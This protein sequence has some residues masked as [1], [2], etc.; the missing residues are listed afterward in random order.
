MNRERAKKLLPV[1]QAFAE[2]KAIEMRPEDD[3]RWVDVSDPAWSHGMEYRIKPETVK[4]LRYKRFIA[5]HRGALYV[6]CQYESFSDAPIWP[7]LFVEW[8]DTEWQTHE[9]PSQES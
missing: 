3:P 7:G 2:G 1:I 5:D 9:V 6:A 8:I 4:T